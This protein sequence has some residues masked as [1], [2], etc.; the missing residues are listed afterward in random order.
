MVI[1][2]IQ[3]IFQIYTLLLF[4]RVLASWAPQLNYSPA[5]R[6]IARYTDPYLNL[7]R[8]LI[9]PLGM[10]DISP[11]IALFCLSFLQNLAISI[12]NTAMHLILWI[13]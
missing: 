6:W 2:F 12:L 10:I 3:L 4:I 8:R 5:I 13:H 7:F 9:P 11:M 1:S